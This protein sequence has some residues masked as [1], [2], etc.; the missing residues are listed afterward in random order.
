MGQPRR[1]A[2]KFL[3]TT[4]RSPTLLLADVHGDRSVVGLEAQLVRRLGVV[5][6]VDVVDRPLDV[7]A[8]TSYPT[9]IWGTTTVDAAVVAVGG[10]RIR[11]LCERQL[12]PPVVR[13]DA[14]DGAR[15]AG[16]DDSSVVAVD[17]DRP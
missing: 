1:D 3:V 16:P 13:V 9:S 15:E 12:D 6:D 5:D 17:L 10:D 8:V 7:S 11:R 14:G 4:S 2:A